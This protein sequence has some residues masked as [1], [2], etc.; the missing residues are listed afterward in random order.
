[1]VPVPRARDFAGRES[2]RVSAVEETA[3]APDEVPRLDLSM[4]TYTQLR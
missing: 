2:D 3:C 1:M 4:D